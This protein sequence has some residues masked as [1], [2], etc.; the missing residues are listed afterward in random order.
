MAY[1]C[2]ICEKHVEYGH[3][4]SHAKNRTRRTFRPNLRF[5]KLR[6]NGQ[7]VRLRICMKCLKRA[8]KDDYYIT[9]VAKTV[10]KKEEVRVEI[11][12][13]EITKT[14]KEEQKLHVSKPLAIKREKKTLAD[15]LS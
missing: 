8:K 5:A 13:K 11:P 9:P 6:L 14:E 3:N 4:V 1:K 2:A 12:V 10:A 7:I 15:A